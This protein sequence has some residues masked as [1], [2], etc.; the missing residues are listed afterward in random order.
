MANNRWQLTPSE[1]EKLAQAAK[2]IVDTTITLLKE[3]AEAL[4]PMARKVYRHY[5]SELIPA[6]E[7]REELRVFIEQ[8]DKYRREVIHENNAHRCRP[9]NIQTTNRS[10]VRRSEKNQKQ[11][12]GY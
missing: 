6:P 10:M 8:K 12:Q 3:L 11:R 1:A 7:G 2:Q 9:Q 5:K 4:A